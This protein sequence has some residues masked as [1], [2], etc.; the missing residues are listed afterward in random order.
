[1]KKKTLSILSVTLWTIFLVT[2]LSVLGVSIAAGEQD[3]DGIV[4]AAQQEG[5][6]TVM[7]PTGSHR[8]DILTMPFRKKY[9]ILVEYRGER[10]SGASPLIGAQQRAGHYMWDVFIGGTTTGLTALIPM[11]AFQSMDP[12]LIS[13]EVKNP[14]NWR[15][16]AIEFVDSGR[17][18][19][20]M[21]PSQRAILFLSNKLVKPGE[22]KSYKDLLK[23]KWK[24][25]IVVDD[26]RTPG[27]GQAAFGFFYMHPALGPE[28]VRALARQNLLI[29]KN[30][31]QEIDLIGQEK[32][33]VLLGD[34]RFCGRGKDCPGPTDP[35]CG[36]AQDQGRLGHQPGLSV[37][38]RFYPDPPSQRGQGLCELA[39]LQGR[40]DRFRSGGGVYQCPAGRSYGPFALACSNPGID[41][42]LRPGRYRH[43]A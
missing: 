37:H 21:A 31:R 20:V 28:F 25:K 35:H 2:G 15:G 30:Y 24:G 41:Q 18:M 29:I 4:K 33:P 17:Q 11:G 23:P 10:G 16:G 12:F 42:N 38:R 26:P 40:P 32:Y 13:A 5:R 36:S 19:L 43:E 1:M 27:P 39:S 3:W 34:I 6:V 9:G 14:K 8:R 7:G 22:I